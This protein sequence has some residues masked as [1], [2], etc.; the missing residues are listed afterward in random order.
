VHPGLQ[1]HLRAVLASTLPSVLL[2]V[3]LRRPLPSFVA[4]LVEIAWLAT[5]LLTIAF[6]AA[7]V[8]WGRALEAELPATRELARLRFAAGAPPLSAVLLVLAVVPS[9]GLWLHAAAP[10]GLSPDVLAI[11]DRSWLGLSLGGAAVRV[12][13]G[14]T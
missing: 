8:K 11:C 12:I 1:W 2:W 10:V 6:A 9:L 5:V 14:M 13:E 3:H 4:W 7:T